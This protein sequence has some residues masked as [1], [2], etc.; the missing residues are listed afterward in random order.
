MTP[1]KIKCKCGRSLKVTPELAGRKIK[2]KNCGQ[3]YRMPASE[4]SDPT[5]QMK[6]WKDEEKP[7]EQ[8]QEHAPN[9]VGAVALGEKM[10]FGWIFASIICTSVLSIAGIVGVKAVL[11]SL[12]SGKA[13]DLQQ[14]SDYIKLGLFWGPSMAFVVSGWVIAR[15]SPGRTISEPAIGAAF[16]VAIL[17]GLVIF[18]PGPTAAWFTIGENVE[19]LKGGNL[20]LQL[21]LFLLGMFNAACL[22]VAGAYFGEVAQERS[23]SV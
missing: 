5:I 20:A 1:V 3:K 2:C 19:L 15:F 13:G 12:A 10:S 8:Q 17:V 4:P 16:T 14:Y 23:A 21:N 18:K 6:A 11:T 9:E 7:E 22:G